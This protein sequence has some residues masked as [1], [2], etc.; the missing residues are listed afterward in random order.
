MEIYLAL[1]MH[2]LDFKFFIGML[3]DLSNIWQINI[4][5][6]KLTFI[7][8]EKGIKYFC[9]KSDFDKEKY[10]WYQNITFNI[11]IKDK[12]LFLKRENMKGNCNLKFYYDS[13][14]YIFM[15]DSHQ[16]ICSLEENPIELLPITNIGFFVIDI[17]ELFEMTRIAH[18]Q[19]KKVFSIYQTN[20]GVK[21]DIDKYQIIEYI[22]VMKNDDY[23]KKHF[24][25]TFEL[26][27]FIQFIKRISMSTPYEDK[28]RIYVNDKYSTLVTN[29]AICDIIC[30]MNDITFSIVDK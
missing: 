25:L 8:N 19:N 10:N 11:N 14:E 26:E 6:E 16:I 21:C 20:S 27:T 2:K 9:I 15:I 30:E 28:L 24:K 3:D 13:H 4:T 17:K 22:T 12:F 5:Q 18:K 29:T 23:I 1:T 7:N